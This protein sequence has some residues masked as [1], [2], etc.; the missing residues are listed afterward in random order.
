MLSSQFLALCTRRPSLVVEQ[1]KELLEFVGSLG[2][3]HGGGHMLTSV[4]R[5][6]PHPCLFRQGALSWG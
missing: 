1:A 2:G 5:R 3:P 6:P 4:V